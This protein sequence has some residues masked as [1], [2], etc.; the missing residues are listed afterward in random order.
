MWDIPEGMNPTQGMEMLQKKVELLGGRSLGPWTIECETLQSTPALS[1][2]YNPSL[3][4]ST[5][6][7]P[8]LPL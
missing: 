1:E 6:T 3:P 2:E 7:H 5:H 4:P 8:P